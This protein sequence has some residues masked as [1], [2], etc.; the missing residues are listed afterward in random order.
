LTNLVAQTEDEYVGKALELASDIPLL[1]SLRMCLR[2]RMLKSKIS[3]GHNF[4]HGLESTY[5]KLWHRYCEGDVPSLR[6]CKMENLPEGPTTMSGI[7]IKDMP[8]D[9]NVKEISPTSTCLLNGVN[10]ASAPMPIFSNPE[11]KLNGESQSVKQ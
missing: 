5:R 3:D 2:E 1:S 11:T 10:T 8:N 9:T 6:R 7:R 4:V